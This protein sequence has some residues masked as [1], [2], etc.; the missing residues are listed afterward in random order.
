MRSQTIAMFGEAE[1]GNFR[2]AY[3][4]DNLPQLLDRLGNPPEN[5]KGLF[6]AVQALLFDRNLIF[7][8]VEEEGFSYQDYLGGLRLLQKEAR[9]ADI[10]AYC[11]PGV[12]DTEILEAVTPICRQHHSILIMTESD[13]YDYLTSKRVA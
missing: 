7:I 4:L 13:L 3:Y 1:K 9:I 2:T 6:Y 5:S 10:A 8:R 11:L 12:G